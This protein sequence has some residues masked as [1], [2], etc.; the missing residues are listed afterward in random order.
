MEKIAI[1]TEF[2]SEYE[3]GKRALLVA[4]SK[5]GDEGL[6]FAK[7]REQKFPQMICKKFFIQCDN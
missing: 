6:K 7:E 5:F 2:K 3:Q 1:A 4:Y